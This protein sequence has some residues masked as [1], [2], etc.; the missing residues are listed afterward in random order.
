MGIPTSFIWIIILFGAVFNRDYGTKFLGYVGINAEPLCV[1]FCNFVQ[2]RI[3]VLT[4]AINEWNIK[5]IIIKLRLPEIQLL[6][7][8]RTQLQFGIVKDHRRTYI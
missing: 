3:F 2:C 8:V 4:S 5:N 6:L 1:E 7:V